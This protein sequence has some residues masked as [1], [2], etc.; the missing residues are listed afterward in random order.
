MLIFTFNLD[1]ALANT[2]QQFFCEQQECCC[3]F[4]EDEN[5]YYTCSQEFAL[6]HNYK[7]LFNPLVKKMRIAP[8][9]EDVICSVPMPN[10]DN[11]KISRQHLMRTLFFN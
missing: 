4:A 2:I 9:C 11:Q 6:R 10:F 5:L 8:K 1:A 7:I 3:C